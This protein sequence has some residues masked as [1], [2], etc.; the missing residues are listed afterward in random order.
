MVTM[1]GSFRAGQPTNAA[2]IKR[3]FAMAMIFK[4]S[5]RFFM[6]LPPV[7]RSGGI[8]TAD[9]PV[10]AKRQ[11]ERCS[12]RRSPLDIGDGMERS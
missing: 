1:T 6:E 3:A 8:V 9:R 12:W 2:V 4:F 10:N 5:D 7:T 11:P